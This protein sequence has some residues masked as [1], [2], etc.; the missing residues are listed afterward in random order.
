MSQT[1]VAPKPP[2][3]NDGGK[4]AVDKRPAAR[5][6]VWGFVALVLTAS[7]VQAFSLQRTRALAILDIDEAGYLSF[8][9]TH[10]LALS[11]SGLTGFIH[12]VLAQQVF[13][14]LVPALG[15]ILM[16]ITGGTLIA[17][18]INVAFY[19]ITA[20][21]GFFTAK[22][23]GGVPVAWLAGT[24]LL[25]T[26][27]LIDYSITFQFVEAVAAFFALSLLFAVRSK[28]FLSLSPSLLMG[29]ALGGMALSRTMTIAFIPGFFLAGVVITLLSRTLMLRRMRNLFLAGITFIATAGFWYI[30]NWLGIYNYLT[31]YGYGSH[32]AEYS[33]GGASGALNPV[34]WWR[35]LE[36]LSSWALAVPLV[37]LLGAGILLFVVRV[38][39][40]LIAPTRI[41]GLLRLE[42]SGSTLV[43]PVVFLWSIACLA[44]TENSGTGFAVVL[45]VPLAIMASLGLIFRSKQWLVFVVLAL[46]FGVL[47]LNVLGKSG[48]FGSSVIAVNIQGD[49][50]GVILNPRSWITS[51]LDG[52]KSNSAPLLG[53]VPAW[54]ASIQDVSEKINIISA[55]D[56]VLF[57][58]RHVLLNPNSVELHYSLAYRENF[59]AQMID[60]THQKMDRLALLA[61]VAP[62]D[63]VP[64]C[65]VL[66]SPGDTGEFTP[67]V[68]TDLVEKALSTSGFTLV[69]VSPMPG[70][71]EVRFWQ[72]QTAC[73]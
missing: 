12:S 44:S 61:L 54:D 72:S 66:T 50:A 4:I 26:P 70:G 34:A 37:A 63:R 55:H 53:V 28:G 56:P 69:E 31:G 60:P 8:A 19:A 16:F 67:I 21:A 5:M 48:V 23:L 13:A 71:R 7:T 36:K 3:D 38:S 17:L 68:D 41:T 58:F 14:P 45:V 59:P 22:R 52:E 27:I 57:A 32:S 39:T 24:L 9:R 42:V 64:P 33:G 11:D 20:L 6:A 35:V 30:P 25:G 47:T 18:T 15:A 2:S 10:F 1:L 65:L 62:E 73:R 40:T 43:L 46:G 51:Y 29:L 49:T